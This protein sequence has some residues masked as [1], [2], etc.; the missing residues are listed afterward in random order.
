MSPEKLQRVTD[1]LAAQDARSREERL[2]FITQL[3]ERVKV[4]EYEAADLR[5][6]AALLSIGCDPMENW[7]RR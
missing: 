2:L 6:K 4:V 7:N 1:E 3:I 5:R